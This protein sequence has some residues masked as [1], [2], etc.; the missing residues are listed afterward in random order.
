MHLPKAKTAPGKSSKKV[1]KTR[2]S[3]GSFFLL[4]LVLAVGVAWAV[5]IVNWQTTTST[6]CPTQGVGATMVDVNGQ[7]YIL[8]GNGTTFVRFNPATQSCSNLAAFPETVSMAATIEKIDNDT[9]YVV[10]GNN[11]GRSY[12][13]KITA[14][15][16]IGFD[17]AMLDSG[18]PIDQTGATQGIGNVIV[19]ADDSATTGT[20]FF[21]LAGN[22]TTFQRYNPT[23]NTWTTR[24]VLPVSA[25]SGAALAYSG[26]G[27]FIYALAGN[28]TNNYRYSISG[29]S[30]TALGATPAA[31]GAGGALAIVGTDLYAFGGN[32]TKNFWRYNTTQSTPGSWTNLTTTST[33]PSFVRGGGA[34]TKIGTTIYALQ[35]NNTKN[36]WKYNTSTGVWN[37]GGT[38]A[39][40]P[41][42]VVAGGALS[43]DGTNVYALRGG[44]TKTMW[45]YTVA[46]DSWS[47]ME[48]IPFAAGTASSTTTAKGGLAYSSSLNEFFAVT[49][50]GVTGTTSSGRGVLWR[51]PLSGTYANTWAYYAA[52]PA[53]PNSNNMR[54]GISLV[55]PGTSAYDPTNDHLYLLGGGASQAFWKYSPANTTWIPWDR[56]KIGTNTAVSQ[57]TL[58]TVTQGSGNNIVEANGE[59]YMAAGSGTTFLK[60]NPVTNKW[61]DLAAGPSFS[62]SSAMVSTDDNTIYAVDNGTIW[63]YT[64]SS[65]TWRGASDI[66][67]ND[68]GVLYSQ[69]GSSQSTGAYMI[70]ANG[71]FYYAPGNTST[72]EEFDPATNTWV[73]LA[74]TPTS[75]TDGT[76][77]A[78]VGTDVYFLDGGALNLYKFDT[79][80]NSWTSTLTVIPGATVLGAGASI[81]YPGSGDY[82]YVLKG[83]NTTEFYRYSI[84][85]NSWTTLASAPATVQAGGS[86]T[87]IGNNIYA[88][89]GN[90]STA[91]YRYDTTQ[92]P[93]SD[94]WT[95]LSGPP[96]TIAA[97]GSLATDTKGTPGTSDD[98]IYATR[99]NNTSTFWKYTPGTGVWRYDAYAFDTF[100][101]VSNTD[102]TGNIFYSPTLGDIFGVTGTAQPTQPDGR[103]AAIILRYKLTPGTNQ[104][105]WIYSPGVIYPGLNAR[106]TSATYTGSGDKFYMLQGS[107]DVGFWSFD[108]DINDLDAGEW[109]TFSKSTL[110]N[111]EPISQAGVSQSYTGSLV[112]V[113]DYF[114]IIPTVD[115]VGTFERYHPASNTW[116]RLA[117]LPV[118]TTGSA[119][120]NSMLYIPSQPDYIYVHFSGTAFGDGTFFRYSIS[121]NA[122]T[123]LTDL[124]GDVWGSGKLI[125]PGAG[126]WIYTPAGNSPAYTNDLWRYSISKELW[127]NF[128]RGRYDGYVNGNVNTNPTPFSQDGGTQNTGN[129]MVTVDSPTHGKK[130]FS[131]PGGSTTFQEFNIETN[132]WTNRASAPTS[133]GF[134]ATLVWD[135]ADVIYA[136]TTSPNFYA[137]CLPTASSCT[138]NGTSAS[139]N[140]WTTLTSP[141]AYNSGASLEIVPGDSEY[142]YLSRGR[143]MGTSSFHRYCRATIAGAT[144]ASGQARNS[145]QLMAALPFSTDGGSS[146]SSIDGSTIYLTGGGFSTNFAAYS[147]SGNTWSNLTSTNPVPATINAGGK[148]VNDGTYLYTT[149]GNTTTNFYRYNPAAASGSRWTSMASTPVTF[150]ESSSGSHNGGIDIIP[151]TNEIWGMPGNGSTGLNTSKGLLYRYKISTDE[152]PVYQVPASSGLGLYRP[153]GVAAKGTDNDI[154][155]LAG[156]FSTSFRKYTIAPD[157]TAEFPTAGSWTTLANAPAATNGPSLD[158]VGSNLYAMR[159]NNRP[160]VMYFSPTLQNKARL[161]GGFNATTNIATWNATTAGYFDITIDGV[162]R[163]I[164]NINFAG[165]T[166]MADVASI[167]QAAI[168]AVT[169]STETVQWCTDFN[170]GYF[171]FESA[172]PAPG[173]SMSVLSASHGPD[174]VNTDISRIYGGGGTSSA[175]L[176]GATGLVKNPSTT[177]D[178]VYCGSPSTPSLPDAP[179]NLGDSSSG[180]DLSDAT[181]S[182]T[183]N[184]IWVLNDTGTT[185]NTISGQPLLLRF[186]VDTDTGTAGDQN[187]WPLL[188]GLPSTPAAVNGGGALVAA[189]SDTLYA[190]RG[191]TGTAGT[192]GFFRYD[193]A[194][195]SW[196]DLSSTKPTPAAVGPGGSLASNGAGTLYATRGSLTP[197]FWTFDV[198]SETWNASGTPPAAPTNVGFSAFT[199]AGGGMVYYNNDVWLV[200]SFG[201][202][203]ITDT[204]RGLLYRYDTLTNSWPVIDDPA[205]NTSATGGFSGGSDI[206][207][208]GG[209]KIYAL[210]GSSSTANR[211]FWEYDIATDTWTS[212]ADLPSITPAGTTADI[213]SG[214]SLEPVYNDTALYASRGKNTKDFC[215]YILGSDS[216][217]CDT[218]LQDLLVNFGTVSLTDDR[219]EL[220]YS[221]TENKLYGISGNNTTVY[222]LDL[223][224]HAWVDS[225]NGGANP[226]RGVPFSVVVKSTDASGDAFPVSQDTTILLSRAAGTGTLGGT[227]TGII[228]NGQSQVTISGVTYSVAESGVRLTATD[229]S[230][231]PSLTASNSDAFTVDEPGPTINSIVPSSGTYAGGNNVTINGENFVSGATVTFDG[232][233]AGVTFVSTS[234]LTVIPPAHAPGAVDVVV[235]NP[236]TQS[237]TEVGGYTYLGPAPTISSVVPNS[238][239]NFGNTPV[240]IS[241][242]NFAVG[243][244][245]TFGGNPATNVTVVDANTITAETPSGSGVVNVVVTNP[246]TQSANLIDGYT[247]IGAE[248]G[249][250]AEQNIICDANGAI[251]ISAVTPSVTFVSRSVAFFSESAAGLSP[252]LDGGLQISIT[253]SRGYDPVV[254]QDCGG[255]STLSIQSSG[256]SNGSTTL[257]LQLGTALTS[258]A[259]ACTSPSCYPNAIGDVATVA[260]SAGPISTAVDIVT[261]SEAFSGTIRTSLQTD[262]LQV[263]PPSGVIP[264]GIYSGTITFTL[265]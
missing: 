29:N 44:A 265:S 11:S 131:F 15:A 241:G 118:S 176:D 70:E 150:G 225:V 163:H 41:E 223:D 62:A 191:G 71:K 258:S 148:L 117:P 77:M 33:P 111:G 261:F 31:V 216:W 129:A 174:A 28:G 97:G 35:G 6:G 200:P 82:L 19:E 170:N 134:G 149:R 93:G 230:A 179:I 106:G 92:T 79:I 209:N 243:A 139:P 90:G 244:T 104:Y 135:G 235:T 52:I 32:N 147:I 145:W 56:A 246:D 194:T 250:N 94:S 196:T 40:L 76:A 115:T 105:N 162:P 180:S 128:A 18:V 91:F 227:L 156:N 63:K 75:Y 203:N 206:A 64:I 219:G 215:K 256:L 165:A 85:G 122:W 24:A 3:L 36:F 157:R 99:G 220:A 39:Q 181:Y 2:Y 211:N 198:A 123:R 178:W 248:G 84:S 54:Y 120:H 125:Y 160:D 10:L 199:N 186:R 114:Y 208:I 130:I 74:T 72:F 42:K 195:N 264:T 95:T 192:T 245:V 252:L 121:D 38:P 59:L 14:N 141:S 257:N 98:V 240:T 146:L 218:P 20:D 152:W 9:I 140:T 107:G 58:N 158:F 214:G 61:T 138:F 171:L 166:S 81:V 46:S 249:S 4:M 26:T 7:L 142:L 239:T 213:Q 168:R 50:N 153:T 27:D 88:F 60:Y 124:P 45:K 89:R 143:G 154:Y 201:S 226:V 224:L 80:T 236:D 210:Q 83:N 69:D 207:S 16:W 23:S 253:D 57:N 164:H 182:P 231:A 96:E 51:Y 112:E 5:P 119:R 251:S 187:E 197:T 175:T 132:T 65:N 233:P 172:T 53:G 161:V 30:W 103:N 86:M 137:Y 34:L 254:G 232:S 144:C 100:G 159:G 259:L 217:T 221:S 66:G 205:D 262:D 87:M 17:R 113:G 78:A 222:Q 48:D 242:S 263:T 229:I 127:V 47:L 169:G 37:S 133:A 185:G 73:S 13:Y 212:K 234:E 189:D 190:L 25:G 116:Y 68:N 21:V 8:A 110:S 202:S 136:T 1:K 247:Y 183:R 238:G 109:N 228:L 260:G 126:D 67:K 155:L 237:D 177:G 255:P 204:S 22:G 12:I 49:G 102:S 173:G 108:T 55:K 184:E 193:F 151:S 167:I 101:Q 43:S 188:R